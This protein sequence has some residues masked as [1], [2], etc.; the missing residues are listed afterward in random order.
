MAL[1]CLA[2]AFTK[3][4]CRLENRKKP[5]PLF[6]GIGSTVGY[7]RVEPG[8]TKF[9]GGALERGRGQGMA[10]GGSVGRRTVRFS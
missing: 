5:G 7:C 3:S 9:L 2:S 6:Y 8:C 1:Y 4:D 10:K